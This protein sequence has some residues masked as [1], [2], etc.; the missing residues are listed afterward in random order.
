MAVA[1]VVAGGDA[2]AVAG[3]VDSAGLGDVDEA[4]LAVFQVVAQETV[5]GRPA[6]RRKGGLL[7]SLAGAEHR[8]LHQVGVEVAVAVVVEQRRTRAGDLGK[9]VAPRHAVEV[10][11]VEARGRGAIFEH[12]SV[13]GLGYGGEQGRGEGANEDCQCDGR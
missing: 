2:D 10:D 12:R 9:V 3:S 1:V 11:E 6:A 13:L 5:A 7:Q 4:R 8:P